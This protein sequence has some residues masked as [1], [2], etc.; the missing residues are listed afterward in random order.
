MWPPACSSQSVVVNVGT[1]PI[2]TQL[3]PLVTRQNLLQLLLIVGVM[4]Y[5]NGTTHGMRCWNGTLHGMRYRIGTSH[6]LR[7]PGGASFCS[8]C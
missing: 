8:S 1:C 7:Y 3:S 2:K 6:G 5:C 4:R